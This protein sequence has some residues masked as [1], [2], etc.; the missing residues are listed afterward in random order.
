MSLT[1]GKKYGDSKDGTCNV[2]WKAHTVKIPLKSFGERW[3]PRLFEPDN[4]GQYFCFSDRAANEWHLPYQGILLV[5][6]GSPINPIFCR[7]RNFT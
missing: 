1:D 7:S 2:M 4:V 5:L 3:W 6:K